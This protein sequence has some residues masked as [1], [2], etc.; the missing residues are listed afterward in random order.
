MVGEQMLL[1]IIRFLEAGSETYAHCKRACLCPSERVGVES[2]VCLDVKVIDL[3]AKEVVLAFCTP[4]HVFSVLTVRSGVEVDGV[5][6][7]IS[8]TLDVVGRS[9]AVIIGKLVSDSDV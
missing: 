6:D 5:L 7:H 2:H 8:R 9:E 3:V 4:G 1:I